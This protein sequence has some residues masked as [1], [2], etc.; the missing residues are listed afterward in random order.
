MTHAHEFASKDRP[1]VLIVGAGFAGLEAAKRLGREGIPVVIVDR[2]NHHLFQPLLYQVA[3]AAL[4]APDVAEPIR[5]IL[6]RYQSVRVVHGEVRTVDT[7]QQ[8][9]ILS[10]GR[11]LPFSRLILATGSV[12]F[13]FGNDDWAVH[14][15]GLKS[16]D[17][18]RRI[19]SKLL[20]SFEQAEEEEDPVE[21]QRLMTFVVIG[22]GPTGV[23]MAGSIAELSRY[24]LARDF[25]R[26]S[27]AEAKIILV[28]GGTR[29]LSG[30]DETLS[31]YAHARLARLGVDVRIGARVTEI[32]PG[33]VL[34]G[35][36]SVATG[37]AIWAAGIGPSTLGAQ[38]AAELDRIG[39]VFVAP[40]LSVPGVP[41][42][43]VL[44]DLAHFV[45]EDGATLPGLAQVAKQQGAHLGRELSAHIRIGK[46]LAPFRY[47]SR[48]NTAIIGRH[49]AIF[50]SGR[51]KLRGWF[52]WI[53]WAI[54][55]VYLLVGFQHRLTVSIQWL[56]RYL[57]YERG[58]RLIAAE[59]VNET[60]PVA[61]DR[62]PE[63]A[64]PTRRAAAT[65]VRPASGS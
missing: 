36:S 57:T 37:L 39:R 4:S 19:R 5:K 16:I 7:G 27:P 24:A 47:R 46:A 45:S 22:G 42:V 11:E 26:I 9:A 56:W 59:H 60:C 12:P 31:H 28:E 14:A 38:L 52:A 32:G 49:A 54:I 35:E 23:E 25:R 29:L 50:E 48:G 53:S 41:H 51:V 63:G 40:D 6:R 2:T 44:G 61:D 1:G 62:R 33:H 64:E 30:F 18:A 65:T 15:P 34:L 17:D 20:M 43:Y 13:Y 21:R 58:A 3:T 8:R 10:D 55:H